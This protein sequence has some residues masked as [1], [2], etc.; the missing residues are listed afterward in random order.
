MA[1][2]KIYLT[3]SLEVARLISEAMLARKEK[4]ENIYS[5]SSGAVNLDCRIPSLYHGKGYFYCI[6]EYRGLEAPK[7][8]IVFA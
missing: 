4:G 3:K 7:Y 8:E 5:T 6:L 1:G 2:Y